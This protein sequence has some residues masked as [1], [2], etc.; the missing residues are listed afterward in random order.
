MAAEHARQKLTGYELWAQMGAPKYVVAP[1][2]DQ[3]ELAFRMMCRKYNPSTLCYTPMI[4]ARLFNEDKHYEREFFTTCEGD[5]PLFVQ[6][7]G[8]DPATL[9]AAAKRIE[10][11]CDA[12]DLNLGCP[13]QIARRGNYGA[14]LAED[15][16][17]V[18]EIVS[19]LDRGLSVPVACKI[20]VQDDLADTLAYAKALVE[21]GCRILCVHGRTREC[22]R[23]GLADWDAIR[24]V[25]ES[26]EIPVIA[27]GNIRCL[28]DCHA[29]LLATGCDAVMSAE[30]LLENP[31]LFAP[32]PS[33]A[34]VLRPMPDGDAAAASSAGVGDAPAAGE[35][36]ML[37]PWDLATEYCDFARKYMTFK[38]NTPHLGMVRAHLFKILHQELTRWP[39]LREAFAQQ[40]MGCA[41]PTHLYDAVAAV[42]ERALQY[43]QGG[44]AADNVRKDSRDEKG[45]E[46]EDAALL[47]PFKTRAEIATALYGGEGRHPRGAIKPTGVNDETLEDADMGGLFG[48]EDDEWEEEEE[49]EWEETC[50]DGDGEGEGEGNEKAKARA[51]ATLES[52]RLNLAS[53]ARTL[54]P[55]SPASDAPPGF[56]GLLK[57]E[58]G[59]TAAGASSTLKEDKQQQELQLLLPDYAAMSLPYDDRYGEAL[60]RGASRLLLLPAAAAAE[61]TSAAPSAAVASAA[62]GDGET[63]GKCFL[64]RRSNGEPNHC[65]TLSYCADEPGAGGGAE[66]VFHTRIVLDATQPEDSRLWLRWKDEKEYEAKT[67]EALLDKTAVRDGFVSV[68]AVAAKA[69]AMALT[70]TET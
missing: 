36:L 31:A 48:G 10:G 56:F 57:A 9:L 2:V 19:T 39:D 61:T 21:A 55:R 13:Q 20:R 68:G 50:C 51:V 44:S 53:L 38:N 16:P 22:G 62:A 41:D 45:E 5:R 6:F 59:A 18:L 58:T 12:V 52:A 3:S 65:L 60:L 69:M 1:M 28:E 49:E 42:R 7:C 26:L 63:T 4:H 37:L 8:N 46:V 30:T 47:V 17:R 67:V 32:L 23:H 43:T 64:V 11:Q 25:K 33:V 54:T 24:A 15:L 35:R 14:F 29:C 40:G 27:N 34:R 70:E 66:E